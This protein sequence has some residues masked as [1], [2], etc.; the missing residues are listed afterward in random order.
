ML[1]GA[2]VLA[3]VIVG[4]LLLGACGEDD[5]GGD[6]GDAV[7]LVA[8]DFSFDPTTLDLPAGE[9]VTVSLVNEDDVEHSFTV[10]DLDV[11]AEAEGGESSEVTFTAPDE[12]AVEF[13]CK[14]HPDQMTGE[15]S[16][17]GSSAG[18]GGGD[19]TKDDS[20]GGGGTKGDY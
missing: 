18:G 9:E 7:E 10:D 16:V 2:S 4:A 14:Y 17:D 20:G 15:I 3:A 12:G 5:G 11:E 6:S 8:Q 1:K 13:H 19:S